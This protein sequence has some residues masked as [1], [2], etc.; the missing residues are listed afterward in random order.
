MISQIPMIR[1]I[2]VLITIALTSLLRVTSLSLISHLYIQKAAKNVG[3]QNIK[4]KIPNKKFN[5]T[6]DKMTIAR[7]YPAK[8]ILRQLII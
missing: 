2:R 8:S 6:K 5:D 7:L 3:K 4:L 1:L